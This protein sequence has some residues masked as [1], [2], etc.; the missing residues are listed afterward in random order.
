[1]LSFFFGSGSPEKRLM[2]V[3]RTKL[4]ATV[5]LLGLLASSSAAAQTG[6]GWVSGSVLDPSG[7]PV[8]GASVAGRFRPGYTPDYSNRRQRNLFH[9][10]ASKRYVHRTWGSPWVCARRPRDA[11][12]RRDSQPDI[13]AAKSDSGKPRYRRRGRCC[14]LAHVA[15][16]RYNMYRMVPTDPSR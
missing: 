14:L 4:W 15:A 3:S 11:T 6:S 13:A 10:F 2:R 7:L 9:P 1:M 8:V 16:L 12:K 5:L